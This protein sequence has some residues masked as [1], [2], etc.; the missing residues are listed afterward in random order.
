MVHTILTQSVGLVFHTPTMSMSC[1][2]DKK[3]FMTTLSKFF[4]LLIRLENG[5]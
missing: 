5:T 2:E 1:E 4:L 3:R